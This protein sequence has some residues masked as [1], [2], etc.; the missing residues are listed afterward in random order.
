MLVG[1]AGSGK[2]VILKDLWQKLNEEGI[3]VL[4]IKA[5]HYYVNDIQQLEKEL[6]ISDSLEK[7]IEK[8]KSKSKQVLILIDQIDAL[9]LSLST[10]RKYLNA[11]RLLVKKLLVINGV[12]VIISVRNWDLKYDADLNFFEE[13]NEQKRNN[14]K[15]IT[16]KDLTDKQVNSVLIH[17]KVNTKNV[18]K[19]LFELLKKPLHLNVFSKIYKHTDK[20]ETIQTLQDLYEELWIQQILRLPK[21]TPAKQKKCIQ[22]LYDLVATIKISTPAKRL[23]NKYLKELDYLK[24]IQLINE[25]DGKV[26]FFHQTF[27]DFVFAKKFIEKE[28]SIAQLLK[29]HEQGLL[30]RA[31]L[32]MILG[33]LREDNPKKYLKTTQKLLKGKKIRF[34]IKY[35]ILTLLGFQDNPTRNEQ[36]FVKSVVLEHDK[37][38]RIFLELAWGKGWLAFF[39]ENS[40]L[41]QLL[42]PIKKTG[43]NEI[44]YS[45]TVAQSR[46]IWLHLLA[47]KIAR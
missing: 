44:P 19:K 2:S 12:K 41:D 21:K 45:E 8:L 3:I 23:Q 13:D 14:Q 9:S 30:V 46:Q 24:S 17:L 43:E 18:P 11:Y 31:K 32:K 16:V 20:L 39:I 27:F 25:K 28:L 10:S 4:G 7:M 36:K 5:D 38:R 47:R 37:Y 22:L 33:H 40:V 1:D 26:Q 35:L 34:H 29:D 42:F 6:G 15:T